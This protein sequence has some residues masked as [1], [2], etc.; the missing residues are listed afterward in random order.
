[1]TFIQ[2]SVN[3]Q[4]YAGRNNFN[5]VVFVEIHLTGVDECDDLF[6]H[7]MVDLRD[8]HYIDLAVRGKDP[9]EP[10]GPRLE[11]DTVAV[12][13]ALL[14]LDTYIRVLPVAQT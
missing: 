10:Q 9:S 7:I 13:F 8:L 2:Q 5:Q 11:D 6:H 3:L 1:M 4:L 12:K 14:A